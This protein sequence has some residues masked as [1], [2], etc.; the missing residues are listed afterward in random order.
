M[1][2][3][4]KMSEIREPALTLDVAIQSLD[5]SRD[6]VLLELTRDELDRLLAE[7][8]SVASALDKIK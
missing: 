8:D 1:M 5:G 6:D 2:S 3:S 7:M 4:D